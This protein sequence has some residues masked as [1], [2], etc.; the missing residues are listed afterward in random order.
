METR[1]FMK[2]FS[3]FVVLS[4]GIIVDPLCAGPYMSRTCSNQ[5]IIPEEPQPIASA[6][7]ILQMTTCQPCQ[8]L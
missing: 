6:H 4:G 7:R 2:S 1:L 8:S 3:K 5:I